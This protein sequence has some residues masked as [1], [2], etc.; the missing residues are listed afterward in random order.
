[1]GESVED[2]GPVGEGAVVAG[3]GDDGEGGE[4]DG[5]LGLGVGWRWGVGDGGD[6]E[7]PSWMGGLVL[8]SRPSMLGRTAVD[9]GVA[10]LRP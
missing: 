8:V 3:F 2:E 1:M 7:V 10:H 6:G 4:V 9:M 5:K